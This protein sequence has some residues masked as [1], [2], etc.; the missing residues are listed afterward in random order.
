MQPNGPD[1]KHALSQGFLEAAMTA[2]PKPKT[3]AI[4]GADAEYPQMALAGARDI[5]KK[6]GLK[7]VYD[8]SYPPS[9]VD[10][11]PDR[12]RHPGSQSRCRLRRLVSAGHRRHHPR[13]ARDR[14][15][16]RRCSAAA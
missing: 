4:V 6:L 8:N 3:L 15:Q 10:Y 7:I 2:K 12:A 13:G 16:E 1:A 11:T 5:A 14:P 9:T